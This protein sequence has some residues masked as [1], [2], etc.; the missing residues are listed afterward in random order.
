MP[1]A[2]AMSHVCPRVAS[3]SEKRRL[4][5][6]SGYGDPQKIGEANHIGQQFNTSTST[7]ETGKKADSFTLL[8]RIIN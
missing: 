5:Q 6:L 3:N 7:G 1:V 8:K 4:S 2:F